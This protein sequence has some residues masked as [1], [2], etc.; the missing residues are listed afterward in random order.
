MKTLS[1][2][3]A[4]SVPDL[5][6]DLARLRLVGAPLQ[7]ALED[8]TRLFGALSAEVDLGERD[9]GALVR[10]IPAEEFLQHLDRRACLP[11]RDQDQGQVAR[12][13]AVAVAPRE[14]VLEIGLG[15]LEIARP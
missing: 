7:E 14:R 15:A 8:G 11:A 13:L 10:R 3:E 12:R 9:V 6:Q 1:V 4:L 5:I 2:P